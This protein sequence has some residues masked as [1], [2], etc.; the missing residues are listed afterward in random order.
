MQ[1]SI[2]ERATIVQHLTE[3]S[4]GRRNAN[5]FVGSKAAATTGLLV[6]EVI[7]DPR[8]F[9]GYN[10]RN[11]AGNVQQLNT[12]LHQIPG[13]LVLPVARNIRL[14]TV[15]ITSEVNTR[16][17]EK[18]VPDP[19]KVTG[20]K[21]VYTKTPEFR[22]WK[23]LDALEEL[24]VFVV[25]V[26]HNQEFRSKLQEKA[27]EEN[28]H[29]EFDR[30]LARGLER[31]ALMYRGKR[32]QTLLQEAE[33]LLT[34]KINTINQDKDPVKS[35]LS[36]EL[37]L[38]QEK[39]TGKLNL[40]DLQEHWNILKENHFHPERPNNWN[41]ERVAAVAAMIEARIEQLKDTPLL[42]DVYETYNQAVETAR[43][44]NNDY[45]HFRR[46]QRMRYRL[47]GIQSFVYAVVV[48][49]DILP[50]SRRRKLY[51]Q[52]LPSQSL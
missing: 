49:P 28:L 2:Q 33:R 24:A 5:D 26:H 22:P 32:K 1:I 14:Q 23:I 15:V 45:S 7:Q 37:I 36:V 39:R 41:L 17:A 50:E 48:P 3:I 43:Q 21:T 6:A 8:P 46:D 29:A 30:D 52:L 51:K 38:L 35:L 12:G 10:R 20:T 44:Q 40:A 47:D 9:L 4:E 27:H 34:N 31:T 42:T 25:G 19:E 16:I 18:E 13:E 11:F